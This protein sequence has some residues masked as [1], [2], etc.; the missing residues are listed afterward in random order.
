[1]RERTRGRRVN[2][3]TLGTTQHQPRPSVVAGGPYVDVAKG[4]KVTTKGKG[5]NTRC[6]CQDRCSTR[7]S[8]TTANNWIH[9]RRTHLRMSKRGCSNVKFW[10]DN[11][12][13]KRWRTRRRSV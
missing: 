1:M 3:G 7:R 4:S 2:E 11:E 10:D 13:I 6:M 12:G 8:T 5:H 9:V